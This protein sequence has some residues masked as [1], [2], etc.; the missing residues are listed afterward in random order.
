MATISNYRLGSLWLVNFDPS[1]GTEIRKTRP[2]MIVS[3]TLF[4]QRRKVTVLPITFSTPD[5]R[6]L[7][8]VVALEPDAN[9]GLTTDSF[10]VC[11][12]PMTFDKQRLVKQLGILKIEK[13]RQVQSILCSYLELD[14]VD[15][16]LD[17]VDELFN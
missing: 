12:D 11:I 4:N 9:N 17:G 16:D 10:I 13:I 8:V 5:S 1:I 3:G 2:A 6:L 7:P 15:S 14:S